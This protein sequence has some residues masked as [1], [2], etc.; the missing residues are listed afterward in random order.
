ML[1]LVLLTHLFYLPQLCRSNCPSHRAPKLISLTVLAAVSAQ[2]V[3][4]EFHRSANRARR[5]R[6]DSIDSID[7]PTRR[8][9]KRRRRER[10]R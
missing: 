9:I 7:S 2:H 10:F 8:Q 6:I 4:P 3:Q 1:V 5:R